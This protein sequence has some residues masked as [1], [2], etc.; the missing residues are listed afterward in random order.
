MKNMNFLF[1]L[2]A[3]IITGVRGHAHLVVSCAMT[4]RVWQQGVSQSAPNETG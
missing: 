3:V 2:Y 4:M 1:E